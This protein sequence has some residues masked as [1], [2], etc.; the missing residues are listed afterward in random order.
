MKWLK[1]LLAAIGG[2]LAIL[3][4]VLL[5]LGGGRGRA[6]HI[7]SIDIDKPADRVFAWVSQPEKL[8]LWVGWMVDIRESHARPRRR[9]CETDLGDGGSQQR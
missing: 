8:K 5:F 6:R 7:H 3:L 4:I 1:Y 2:L 9:R